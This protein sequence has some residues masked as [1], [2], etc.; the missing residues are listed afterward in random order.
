M[1]WMSAPGLALVILAVT[2]PAASGQDIGDTRLEAGIAGAIAGSV[3]LTIFDDVSARL[4][5]GEVILQGKVTAPLKRSDVET[6]VARVEGVRT[7]RNEIAVLPVS[8]RDDELRYRVARAIYGNP[9]F[10]S[11]AARANP[12]IHVIVEHGRVTLTGVVH[13]N[14]ERMLAHSLA[15]GV[16]GLSVTNDL[17]TDVEGE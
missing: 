9:S 15:T 1:K 13:S 4:E 8:Q 16:G 10:W 7:V 12:P 11:Y 17:R 2:A 6:R 5:N 3:H 14:V